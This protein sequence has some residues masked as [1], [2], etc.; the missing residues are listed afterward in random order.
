ML[1]L[2]Y[3]SVYPT[4]P[5]ES[6]HSRRICSIKICILKRSYQKASTGYEFFYT[7]SK[8]NNNNN[9]TPKTK[10]QKNKVPLLWSQVC[11]PK[12]A[13][14]EALTDLP[15]GLAQG[16]G[17]RWESS[18]TPALLPS[19]HLQLVYK[20]VGKDEPGALSWWVWGGPLPGCWTH[21]LLCSSTKFYAGKN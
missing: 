21:G 6:E 15:S 11:L 14:R 4:A 17:H 12:R 5:C 19:R 20:A 8:N 3:S 9:K 2:F 18:W 16:T 1:F 10:K 13:C 7:F